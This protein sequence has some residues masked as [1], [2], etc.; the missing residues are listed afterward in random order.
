[1]SKGQRHK[2]VKIIGTQGTVRS[3]VFKS[4]K[5]GEEKN[6]GE[7]DM[8]TLLGMRILTLLCSLPFILKN[9][10]P[11]LIQPSSPLVMSYHLQAIR[12]SSKQMSV[13]IP[14]KPHSL[15]LK[16]KNYSLVRER[17]QMR[18][19][20]RL[21]PQDLLQHRI[22]LL[23]SAALSISS[24]SLSGYPLKTVLVFFFFF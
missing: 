16:T 23:H 22:L 3:F 1:M 14:K 15:T 2:G 24:K 8:A 12:Q 18:T 5:D 6:L 9:W 4:H 11:Q 21:E 13:K 10:G 19:V 17:S 7:K 20:L